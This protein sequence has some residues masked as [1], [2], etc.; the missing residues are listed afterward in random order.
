[1]FF[2]CRGNVGRSQMAEALMQRLSPNSI[3]VSS[4]GTQLSGPEQT[5]ESLQPKTDHVIAVMD[6][7]GIDVRKKVR[8][9]LTEE[10]LKDA[11]FIIF[12]I[13]EHDPVPSFVEKYPHEIWNIEDP[14]GKNLEETRKIK[15]QIKEKT[16]VFIQ[17]LNGEH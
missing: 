15:N 4:A 11:D 8:K 7:E 10:M 14:K 13:D 9:Q 12:T 3:K 5:I 6:E 16:Q 1:M 17:K 2:I